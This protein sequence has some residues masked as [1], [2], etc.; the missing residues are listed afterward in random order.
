MTPEQLAMFAK[1]ASSKVIPAS[2]YIVKA[3]LELVTG[4]VEEWHPMLQYCAGCHKL[5]AVDNKY[6]TPF[7][8]WCLNGACKYDY[9]RK[10]NEVKL[11]LIL[12]RDTYTELYSQ[13]PLEQQKE[14]WVQ[15]QANLTRDKERRG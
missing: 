10:S 3:A 12:I 13:L 4:T 2:P 9:Y 7:V 15:L 6:A 5:Y 11:A 1:L 8:T 14:F